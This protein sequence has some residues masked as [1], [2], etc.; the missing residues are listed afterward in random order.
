MSPKL[1]SSMAIADHNKSQYELGW[2]M[3]SALSSSDGAGLAKMS[4]FGSPG[5]FSTIW[6]FSTQSYTSR[7]FLTTPRRCRRLNF[8]NLSC[9]FVEL[10]LFLF[11]FFLI[12]TSTLQLNSSGVLPSAIF[13]TSRG[14]RSRPFSPLVRAFNCFRAEDS[15]FPLLVDFRGMLL[16]HALAVSANQLFMEDKSPD[17]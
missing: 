4:A 6:N 17:E 9:G 16:T 12:V 8:Q 13:W 1:C 2:P 7:V 15:A 5:V 3:S 14:H 10:F 11:H